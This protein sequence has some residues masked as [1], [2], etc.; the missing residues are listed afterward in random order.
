MEIASRQNAILFKKLVGIDW[1]RNW[2]LFCWIIAKFLIYSFLDGVK[3]SY[4]IRTIGHHEISTALRPF[5]FSVHPDLFGRFP[6]QRVSLL[7]RRKSS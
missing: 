2:V 7:S 1:N 6:E 3:F 5:Y 4:Q